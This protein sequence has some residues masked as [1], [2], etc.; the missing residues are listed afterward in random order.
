M[1]ETSEQWARD[2]SWDCGRCEGII[3]ALNMVKARLGHD[4]RDMLIQMAKDALS[5]DWRKQKAEAEEAA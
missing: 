4:D 3:E 2:K 5:G 1:S